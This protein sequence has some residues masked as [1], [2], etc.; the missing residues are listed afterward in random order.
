MVCILVSISVGVFCSVCIVVV[1]CIVSVVVVCIVVVVISHSYTTPFLVSFSVAPKHV[2]HPII[3]KKLRV[4]L[5][6][7]FGYNQ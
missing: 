4:T 5:L 1:V 7:S 6:D 2:S 3:T